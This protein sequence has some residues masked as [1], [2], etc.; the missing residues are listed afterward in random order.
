[1]IVSRGT[2]IDRETQFI[3]FLVFSAHGSATGW[4]AESFDM[5]VYG[6]TGGGIITAVSGAR[7]GLQVALVE[8]G[9]HIGGMVSGG[10]SLTDYGKKE[11]SADMRSSSTRV[12][13]RT[14]T[15]AN[16]ATT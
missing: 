6:A 7:E 10:L 13:G 14:I 9:N 1:M 4:S 3:G 2:G 12:L 8:P 16:S 11:V 5:V 15:C